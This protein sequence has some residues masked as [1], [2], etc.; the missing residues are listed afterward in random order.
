LKPTLLIAILSTVIILESAFLA[1]PYLTYPHTSG[2]AYPKGYSQSTSIPFTIF[3][4]PIS[5]STEHDLDPTLGGSW[6][7]DIQSTLKPSTQGRVT[8]AEMA[9]APAT[10][11]EGHSIP[12]IIVQER[13]DGL[14]RVE[15][16]AQ[17][18]PNTYGLLLYNSTTQGLTEGRNVT[19]VFRSSGPPSA[20]DPQLAPRPNGNLD[21]QIG[22]ATVVSAYPIAWANLSEVYLYGYPGSSFVGGSVQ[23]TFYQV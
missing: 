17:N 13:A 4:R 15:Y 20:V 1:L 12:T 6:E 7:V 18:W 9:F 11:S 16:F 23:L 14:L 8:E 2:V 3:N 22:G 5:N 21:L 19:L 10:T